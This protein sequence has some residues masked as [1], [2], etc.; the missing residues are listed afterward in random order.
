MAEWVNDRLTGNRAIRGGNP[1]RYLV[2]AEKIDVLA[3]E[4]LQ[5]AK[6][7]ATDK[8][9][10]VVA[11]FSFIQLGGKQKAEFLEAM[12]WPR[13]RDHLDA[14]TYGG[15]GVR[16][17]LRKGLH[18]VEAPNR[19]LVC[20]R[21]DDENTL[22]LQGD[23]FDPKENFNLL[24][25]AEFVTP[26]RAG[27]GGSYGLGKAVLWRFSQI[28]TVLFSSTVKHG[29][30]QDLRLFG[31]ADIPSRQLHGTDYMDG[32]FFGNRVAE[33]GTAYA[34]SIW[35]DVSL[36]RA[37]QVYRDPTGPTGT[38]AL[39]VGFF[40]PYLEQTS[41][42]EAIAKA[43]KKA[44]ERWFWPVI[45]NPSPSMVVEFK[46]VK[47]RRTTFRENANAE[48][49]WSPFLRAFR[50]S[51]TSEKARRPGDIA[52]TELSV[53]VPNRVDPPPLVHPRLRTKVKL[54]A[55]RGDE[56]L[57]AHEGANTIACIRGHGMVVKYETLKRKP[58][59][60]KPAFGVL[61]VGSQNGVLQ[62]DEQTEEF[63]RLAEPPLHN[64][65]EYTDAIRDQYARGGGRSLKTLAATAQ[66]EMFNLVEEDLDRRKLGPQLLA[67][68]FPFGGDG[69]KKQRKQ[70]K[71]EITK[72]E[73]RDPYWIVEGCFENAHTDDKDWRV[74]LVFFA[75]AETGR[76]DPMAISKL[77]LGP[78]A[79]FVLRDGRAEITAEPGTYHVDFAAEVTPP[80]GLEK[81]DLRRTAIL[82][83][84]SIPVGTE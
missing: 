50:D 21:I 64:S 67:R 37:L 53:D 69:S 47:N 79:K 78:S 10:P 59:D 56:A 76:G 83:S 51:V 12:D 3:R 65:W 55:T 34:A 32:G 29:H 54:R 42:L 60:G 24:C 6:D 36:C 4:S 45:T 22:G 49:Y 19:P 41:E 14:V 16:A 62:T 31:R 48:P 26:D 17:Q 82:M 39:I 43:T 2:A 73:F 18:N 20:L 61:K 52:E 35:N 27:R 38:T 68:Q 15:G 84:H 5:N 72:S 28:S 33:N 71:A 66:D 40:E 7:Q 63:F 13:H 9:K 25:R 44:V 74:T 58:L 11:R 80:G 57:G 1:S 30:Q 23:E 75:S 46:V 70:I 81:S 8:N 77:R